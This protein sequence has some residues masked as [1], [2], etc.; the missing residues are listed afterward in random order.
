M[1]DTSLA[2]DV[3]ASA[4]APAPVTPAEVSDDMSPQ[5]MASH[6]ADKWKK[7]REAAEAPPPAAEPPP[8][9][10]DAAPPTEAPG[11]TTEAQEPAEQPP[12]EAPRS[13]TAEAKERFASLPRET[14]E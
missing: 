10:Q 12:I 2:P 8:Q 1:S 5:E 9:V 3:G 4:P 11:E 7:Q 14:Q 6:L 13:W